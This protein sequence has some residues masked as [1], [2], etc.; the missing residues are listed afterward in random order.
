MKN[1]Y[2]LFLFFNFAITSFS[3]TTTIPDAVFE[4][5]LIDLG[6]DT[7]G[8]NGDILNSDAQ[9]VTTLDVSNSSISDLTGIKAFTALTSLNCSS[10]TLSS[11]NVFEID[12]LLTLFCNNNNLTQLFFN[13]NLTQLLCH[14]NS[15]TLLD[16]RLNTGLNY[17]DC[18]NNNLYSL[19]LMNGNN[20][21][22]GTMLA[23]TNNVAYINVDDSVGANN[24]TGI[25]SGLMWAKD[26]SAFYAGLF[27]T[28]VPDDNFEQALIDLGY[29]STLDDYVASSTI[30]SVFSLDISNKNINDLTGIEGFNNL[31]VLTCNSN[32]IQTLDLSHNANLTTVNANFNQI[33]N[34]FVQ[35]CTS[36]D[37]LSITNNSLA[38][39]NI[40]QNTI[41]NKLYCNANNLTSLDVTQNTILSTLN[42]FNNPLLGSLDVSQNINLVAF[43]C[44]NNGLISL[45]VT[46]NVNLTSLKIFTNN[47]EF[48][49]LKQNTLLTTMD[50]TSNPSLSCIQVTNET[51]ANSGAGIY[52]NWNK[53]GGTSYAEFCSNIY[54][55][56][57]DNN[58][59]Q[60]LINLGYDT[61]LDN[62]VLTSNIESLT[63]LGLNGQSISD[64]T[65]IEDFIAL[66]NLQCANNNL[67]SLNVTQNINLIDLRCY[68]NLLTSLDVTQNSLLTD[69][70][71]GTNSISSLDISQ[72]PALTSLRV[73]NNALSVLDISSNPIL[74]IL[75][76]YNNNITEIDVTVNTALTSLRCY[77]NDL[78]ALD[79]VQNTLLTD[80]N[81]TLN[82]NLTCIQVLDATAATANMGI[83]TTWLKGAGASYSEFCL[84]FYTYVPDNNF[85]QALID[86]GFDTTLDGYV[87][88]ANIELVT[89]LDVSSKNIIAL[90]GIEAFV[91]LTNLDCS[92][93]DLSSLYISLNTAL[94]TLNCGNNLIG[95]LNVSLNTNLVYL[96][97]YNNQITNLN[98]SQNIALLLLRCEGNQITNLNVSQNV[99]L[100]TLLCNNNLLTTLD[101]SVNIALKNLFCNNNQI[102]NLDISLNPL[103]A[104]FECQ[105]NALTSLNVKNGN[106]TNFILFNSLNNPNLT[107]IEVDD[108]SY[109]AINW[110]NVDAQTSFSEDCNALSVDEFDLDSAISVYPN[111]TSTILNINS[112]L[113]SKKLELYTLLG[114]KILE[115]NTNRIDMSALQNS[116]YL[117][118]I[119]SKNN[120]ITKK[121]IKE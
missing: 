113:T 51:D 5:K 107:C 96:Y 54:T 12:G 95:A 6:I 100:E 119:Y 62:Y 82:T 39:L 67:T 74:E 117:L 47:L 112:Q 65:G 84:E 63:S 15:L 121:I 105:Y 2:I 93:N 42:C 50:A 52:T 13:S 14:F 68:Q 27:N 77:N 28:Y 91:A 92:S 20:A 94:T 57:P 4:Q 19:N 40:S 79:L 18:R 16:L 111:P 7:N 86:L 61:T 114:E 30:N 1:F 90:T 83:Y 98:V 33:E 31:T 103:M 66:E 34:L 101:V 10:N 109:S 11:L 59:E 46:A 53:D 55:Y 64:L 81:A 29:D 75:Y 89:T 58:F 56:V 23:T 38:D 35:N 73:Q 110:A 118:K 24:G 3:Q 102:T 48:I 115:T 26:A 49:D 32:N 44:A 71:C 25:Y 37:Y 72:N 21:S 69:L 99:V 88:T 70:R 87:L 8:L 80:M 36:L 78:N 120:V 104:Y 85:E 60:A 22:L 17:L 9:S 43:K 108:A 76:L 45:D 116:I 106:N 41:L 97:C